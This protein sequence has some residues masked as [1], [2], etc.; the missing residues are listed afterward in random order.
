MKN[1]KGLILPGVLIACA[2]CC[3]GFA[4]S[5]TVFYADRGVVAEPAPCTIIIDGV[6]ISYVDAIGEP[7]APDSGAAVWW[8]SDSTT[9]GD[10]CYFIGHDYNAFGAV[11]A[12]ENGDSVTV[13]DGS[14]NSHT[15]Y[16]FD[17]FE[18]PEGTR[19]SEIEDRFEGQ[20]ESIA[21]QTCIEG[22]QLLVVIAK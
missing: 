3:F 15:Y 10:F 4:F 8:G 6:A 1:A 17:S 20:G 13:M 12:L 2:L 18:M 19:W 14:G 11:A 21:M 16:V 22:D 7:S 9:D 5:T